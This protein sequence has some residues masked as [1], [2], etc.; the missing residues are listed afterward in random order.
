MEFGKKEYLSRK[1]V[2]LSFLAMISVILIHSIGILTMQNPAKWNVF[3][4]YLLFRSFT[5]WSVPFFFACSGF[6]FAKGS[7]MRSGG[8]FAFWRTKWRTLLAP[9][10]L[11]AVIVTLV[12]MPLTVSNNWLMHRGLWE[13]TVLGQDGIWKCIDWMIGVNQAGPA[14][15]G[16]L[17]YLRSLILLFAFAPVWRFIAFMRLGR[18]ILLLLGAIEILIYPFGVPRLHFG[19]SA[20][21]WFALGMVVALKNWES[22]RIPKSVIAGA[23]VVWCGAAFV[24]CFHMIGADFFS[25]ELLWRIDALIPVAGIIC[26]WGLY[27]Y[28]RLACSEPKS[29]MRATFFVFCFHQVPA[30]YL[31]AIGLYVFGKNDVA[32]LLVAMLDVPVVF[33]LSFILSGIVRRRFKVCYGLLTG[34]RG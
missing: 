32:T 1:C 16:P 13:R 6:W 25:N 7:Y 11:W 21:G 24:K 22:V 33:C 31:L 8:L 19:G 10:V 12:V 27:D 29:W 2:W 18:M 30:A 3:A 17:W 20:I 23:A 26:L 34:G 28:S 14:V 4:Q 9:Y 15:N 5:Y